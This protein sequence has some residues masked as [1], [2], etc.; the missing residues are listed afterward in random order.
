LPAIL[1]LGVHH[2]ETLAQ[3]IRQLGLFNVLLGQ[4]LFD[5]VHGYVVNERMFVKNNELNDI[6]QR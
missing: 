2:V 4:N 1:G 6:W 3:F 5:S